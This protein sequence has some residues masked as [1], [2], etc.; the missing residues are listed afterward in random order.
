MGI[1]EWFIK[2][3]KWKATFDCP[4]GHS[5]SQDYTPPETNEKDV[6]GRRKKTV[7]NA[8]VCKKCGMHQSQKI[9]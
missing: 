2:P 8:I 1:K 5:W 9:E 7:R 3:T 4:C 6:L